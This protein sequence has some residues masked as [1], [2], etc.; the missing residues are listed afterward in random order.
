MKHIIYKLPFS[1]ILFAGMF[2]GMTKGQ[3]VKQK[4]VN[5][6]KNRY[7]QKRSFARI[8]SNEV[9]LDEIELATYHR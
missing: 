5:K 2:V 6:M 1:F 3:N 4:W 9:L 7:E 8:Q